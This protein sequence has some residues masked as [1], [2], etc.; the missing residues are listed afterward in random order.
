MRRDPV[1][2]R[3][4]ENNALAPPEWRALP[5][6]RAATAATKD[7]RIDGTDRPMDFTSI[8]SSFYFSM[9]EE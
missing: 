3:S 8:R 1:P 6:R 2:G 4:A 9:R 7:A 5:R